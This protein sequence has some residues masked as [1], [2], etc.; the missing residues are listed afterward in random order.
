MQPPESATFSTHCHSAASPQFVS[1]GWMLSAGY[2]RWMF[3]DE[4]L[5]GCGKM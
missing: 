1:A 3:A 2:S 4:I 5:I